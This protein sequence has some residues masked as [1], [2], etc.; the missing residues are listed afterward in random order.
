M[1]LDLRSIAT[2]A[3]R[4]F[5]LCR[6]IR[7]AVTNESE[8]PVPGKHE[9]KPPSHTWKQKDELAKHV[10][11]MDHERSSRAFAR[12]KTHVNSTSDNVSYVRLKPSESRGIQHPADGSVS[13]SSSSCEGARWR[14]NSLARTASTPSP[15]LEVL[16]ALGYAHSLTYHGL[17]TFFSV[18]FLQL[19]PRP[20]THKQH[21]HR[22]RWDGQPLDA[23]S[24]A[25]WFFS[26]FHCPKAIAL[27][28]LRA[29][30][31]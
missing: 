24:R 3:S 12:G 26:N 21:R 18:F 28:L 15:V 1:S 5:S 6:N 20:S 9:S 30:S 22:S 19:H 31:G 25:T 7:T 17:I 13:S 29:S 11:M 4:E 8:S 10:L 23:C 14:R 2:L 16:A 27:F